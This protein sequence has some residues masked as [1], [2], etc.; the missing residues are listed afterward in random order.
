MRN[1]RISVILPGCSNNTDFVSNA[2]RSMLNQTFKEF[3]C[4]VV[5]DGSADFCR[6]TVL[7]CNDS[8]I[9]LVI[10]PYC[11]GIPA[12][13]N[14]GMRIAEG[15]YICFMEAEDM[16]Y[17][18]RLEKLIRYLDQHPEVGL[19]GSFCELQDYDRIVRIPMGCNALKVKLFAG[20]PFAPS[21]LVVRKSQIEAQELSHN[22][23]I[24]MG[25]SP[26]SEELEMHWKLMRCWPLTRLETSLAK[27]WVHKLLL[28]NNR[29]LRCFL[30]RKLQI[31]TH[32]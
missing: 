11:R 2:I 8:R 13:R 14:T 20:S 1:P 24:D 22:E 28:V 25:L 31:A 19:I 23:L 29:L 16:A 18:E 3:E 12:A 5:V 21:S 4:I 17:P 27:E 26:E 7:Y 32:S 9:R 30:K 15:E 10:D 6:E